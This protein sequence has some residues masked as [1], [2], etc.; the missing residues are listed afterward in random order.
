[1]DRR[2]GQRGGV[3]LR[4]GD[5]GGFGSRGLVDGIS[6]PSLTVAVVVHRCST[7][8]LRRSTRST[9][10]AGLQGRVLTLVSLQSTTGGLFGLMSAHL[11]C[12]SG[13]SGDLAMHT[14]SLQSSLLLSHRLSEKTQ[15]HENVP[16]AFV[17]V[18]HID[19]YPHLCLYLC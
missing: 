11:L 18:H 6:H 5:G 2:G 16:T 15:N 10:R 13:F 3:Q 1:M 9:R 8:R 12:G 7:G 19:R 17:L 14:L 4:G